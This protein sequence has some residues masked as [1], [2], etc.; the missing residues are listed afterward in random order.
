[1]TAFIQN[2][3]LYYEKLGDN[4]TQNE[5]IFNYL[6]DVWQI[7]LLKEWHKNQVIQQVFSVETIIKSTIIY[8]Y[9]ILSLRVWNNSSSFFYWANTY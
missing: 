4:L 6:K 8:K 1:M 2:S 7:W 9:K 3:E 5:I